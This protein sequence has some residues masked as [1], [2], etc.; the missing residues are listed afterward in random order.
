VKTI[1]LLHGWGMT[2]AVFDELAAG[3]GQRHALCT[4]A[5]PGYD[6]SPTCIPYSFD[7]IVATLSSHAPECCHVAGWSFGAHVALHWAR[8]KP[9]QVERLAL[10][11]ATPCF[12]RRA[13]W[14]C[15]M[16]PSVLQ[17]FS[18]ALADDAGATLKRFT[19][20]QAQGDAAPKRVV[21]KLRDALVNEAASRLAALRG[22]LDILAQHD[23]RPVLAEIAHP[24][25]LVH[26]T[27]DQLVPLAAASHIARTVPKA[28]LAVIDGAAHAPFLSEPARVARL[29]S[30][31]FDGR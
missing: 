17:S 6:S 31:H 23:F 2:P 8:T 21:Q 20:L 27:N 26:G 11:A 10:I 22:G 25:L 18:D 7:E 30:E 28:Q 4:P 1:V 3:L 15:A 12:S 13:D 16:D 9:E 24:T 19:L 14:S 5:L 29:L